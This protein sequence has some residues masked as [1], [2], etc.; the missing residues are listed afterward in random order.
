MKEILNIDE[1][2]ETLHV[3]SRTVY[4][5]LKSGKI[6]GIKI[7]GQWRFSREEIMKMFLVGNNM[8]VHDSFNEIKE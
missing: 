4:N 8:K 2:A 6:P 5:L 7:G 3:S 1:V